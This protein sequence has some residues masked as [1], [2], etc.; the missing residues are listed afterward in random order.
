MTSDYAGHG[1][2]TAIRVDAVAS[3]VPLDGGENGGGTQQDAASVKYETTA[4]WQNGQSGNYQFKYRITVTNN[5][6][7]TIE[8]WSLAFSLPTDRINS[9]FSNAQLTS[10]TPEG[11]NTI[12]N[13][14]YNNPATDTIAPGA[15]V[16][17]EGNAR[18]QG[19]EAIRNVTVGGSNVETISDVGI[20]TAFGGSF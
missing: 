13:P 18:G 8:D 15:S 12:V 5:S 17:F 2:G 16:S 1:F 9:V 14:A 10:S 19:T 3:Q 4:P 20:E 7:R 11:T 6:D